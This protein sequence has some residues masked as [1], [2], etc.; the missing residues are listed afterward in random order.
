MPHSFSILG[1]PPV[2]VAR[3]DGRVD[4]IFLQWVLYEAARQGHEEN[5]RRYM[6]DLRSCRLDLEDS[7]VYQRARF[8]AAELPRGGRISALVAEPDSSLTRFAVWLSQ[9]ADVSVGIAA[10]EEQAAHWLYS[11]GQSTA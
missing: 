3:L 4:L 2:V 10:T 8:V 11:E 6:I 9:V 7:D 5:V 1:S